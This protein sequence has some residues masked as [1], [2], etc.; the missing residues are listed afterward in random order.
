MKLLLE[1]YERFRGQTWP[2]LADIYRGLADGQS[3]RILV[4]SCSD[5]RTDPATI[6]DA[7]PGELFIV[8]NV[9]NL[10]PPF[11]QGEGFHG[12]SAAIEFAVTALKVQTILVLGHARCGGCAAALAPETL[13]PGSFLATWVTLLEPAKQRIAH[14]HGDKHEALE[15]ES[16]KVAME[17]LRTF[18]FVAEALDAKR[19]SIVGARFDIATGVLE[20]YDA[21]RNTFSPLH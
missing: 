20:M 2:R 17:N 14:V 8:R 13:N 6:F 15:H 1:G 18:P 12:T 4:I 16:I 9:A 10:V 11:E 21:E 19:L 5:S 3:P 7:A